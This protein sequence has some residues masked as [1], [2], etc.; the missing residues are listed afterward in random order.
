MEK[1]II[2]WVPAAAIVLGIVMLALLLVER[3]PQSLASVAVTNDYNSTIHTSADTGTSSVKAGVGSFGSIVLS[4]S[5]P[6]TGQP[7]R[8]YD[9]GATTTATTSLTNIAEFYPVTDEGTYTFDIVLTKGLFVD[10][11]TDFVG[12]YTLTYR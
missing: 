4:S 2:N 6:A 11:P 9:S 8:F 5:S 12:S 1:Q 3:V 10:I 7:I